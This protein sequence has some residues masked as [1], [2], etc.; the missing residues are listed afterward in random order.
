MLMT[1]YEDGIV[2]WVYNC[3][4]YYNIESTDEHFSNIFFKISIFL[5]IGSFDTST[6]IVT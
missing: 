2:A 1:S 6:K 3:T 5:V 4:S